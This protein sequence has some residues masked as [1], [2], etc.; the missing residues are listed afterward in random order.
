MQ[1]DYAFVRA[2]VSDTTSDLPALDLLRTMA[3][4]RAGDRREGIL[5]RQGKGW[6]QIS[7]A[8]HEALAAIAYSLRPD[9]VVYTSYRDRALAL[10]RGLSNYNIALGYFAKQESSSAGRQMP[11]HYSSRELGL[12]SCATPTGLQCIPAAGSAWACKLAGRGQ[13]TICTIGDAS[14]RQGDFYEGLCFALQEKLPLV[15]V[16]EDNGYGIST[17]TASMNP[18]AI[19]VLSERAVVRVNGRF[20]A[21]VHTATREA[22]ERAREGEGPT[23]LWVELDRLASHT[24]SDDHRIYRAAED[25]AAMEERDPIALLRDELIARNELTAEQWETELR[26]IADFVDEDYIR[27]ERASDP[28]PSLAQTRIF[29]EPTSPARSHGLAT[30]ESW[31]IVAAVNETLRTA[32]REDDR[33]LMFGEDIAD[34][35]GGV[36]GLTKGLSSEFG[37]RVAN[38]PLAEATIAGVAVGLASAGY[39][40]VFELQFIDFVG[41]AFNQIVNQMATLRWRSNGDWG[42][43]VVLIAPCG[44]YLPAGGP[45]HSQTNEA[46][47]AHS[48]GLKIAMPSTPYDA[49]AL[50]RTALACQDPTL[51]LLPKH[52]FR[53]RF[54]MEAETEISLGQAVVRNEG[55]DVT[56]VG[57][58][59]CVEVARTAASLASD[60]GIS[61]E[62]VDVRTIAPLDLLT[63]RE[64]VAKTG[65]LVVVQEDVRSCSVGQAIISD[66]H[67]R[68]DCWDLFAAPPQLVSRPDAHIGFHPALEEA[69]LPSS[70]QV[71]ESIRLV[72]T[73]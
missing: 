21:A 61:C 62:I 73:F 17:P 33:L 12:F 52:L 10:A 51:I 59:N 1:T 11:G 18:L 8:G 36:F 57:W 42:C 35:K 64:S 23:V 46:W 55:S 45:W 27:A 56:I 65:R 29:A 7:A 41:P 49:A 68:P 26:Q 13:V 40:P 3:R 24:S 47:F 66:L 70:A 43:P 25:I 69:V 71:L 34:P 28:D 60:E 14:T 19:G 39:R 38:S 31:T 50:L 37:E 9:D 44:A 53:P 5:L 54:S 6:F 63:L 2:A 20:S 48:P 22:V 16:V 58:G 67:S 32:M 30:Q 4:S 15:F 72:M